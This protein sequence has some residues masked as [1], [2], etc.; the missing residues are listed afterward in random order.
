MTNEFAALI[1]CIF[2]H[3]LIISTKGMGVAYIKAQ[4]DEAQGQL[5]LAIKKNRGYQH[6]L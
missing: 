2:K 6:G 1:Y 5:S 3:Q 4:L